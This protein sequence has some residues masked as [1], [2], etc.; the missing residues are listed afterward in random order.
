MRTRH[1]SG[2]RRLSNALLSGI[3]PAPAQFVL[4]RPYYPWLVVGTTCI[5]AFIGQVDASIVQLALPTLE[6]AFNARLATVS[7]VAVGYV[8]AFASILPVFARVAE[9]AGRKLMYLLGFALFGS[10]S[11]LCGLAPN[12]P[13]L[14]AF[15]MLQGVSGAMLGANSIVIL[16][17][18]AGPEKR[19][20]AMGFFASA[21]AVGI[22]V[23]PAVG[24]FL[25][26]TLDWRWIFWVSVPFAFAAVVIGW[27]VVPVTAH[28][29]T[30]RRFDLPG[31]L[32][33]IP[34][35]ITLL[36]A[37][38]E[39]HAWGLTSAGTLICVVAAV[40]LLAA[41]I[42]KERKMPAPLIDLSLF[43]A[44]GFSGGCVAVALSYAM[45]YGMFFAMSFALV[46]GYH[47]A[48]LAAG[49]R[50]TI[51]PIGL[52]VVAPFSGAWYERRPRLVMIG[53]MAICI[54]AVALLTNVMSGAPRSL[55]GVMV[56]LAAFG[57][58]LGMF[59]APNNSA[60]L[61]AAPADKSGEAGGLLNLMRSFGTG[62]G[63]AA[64]TSVLA[65]RLELATGISGRTVAVAEPA[66]LGAIRDV[67]L[68]LAV[69]AL[70][71]GAASL[72][73]TDPRRPKR[74]FVANNQSREA[75]TR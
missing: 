5:A 17:A 14:I 58:G 66:L 41:F 54:A 68:M 43:R 47:D 25:L 36:T 62:I 29:D 55:P 11:L 32:L 75:A 53:G 56:A 20:R 30:D 27:L 63:V 16:V 8:L 67:L 60:T 71:A 1:W 12:L 6:R 38:L 59:I 46:R 57:A 45:L 52:G 73:R 26:S 31:A 23:G 44:A 72:L 51:I 22:S 24:G 74:A 70:I 21:Q 49:L 37:I 35:L 33:L 15:R 4:R 65:W 9:I 2:A 64:A 34:A 28:T 69:F 48:P 39:S 3:E 18:A 50:L 42:L 7:W 61:G 10:S 19:G 40:V 13:L